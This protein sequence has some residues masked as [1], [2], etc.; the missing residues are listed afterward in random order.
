MDT[1][2]KIKIKQLQC[3]IDS[4]DKLIRAQQDMIETLK[5]LVQV[6]EL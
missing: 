3:V 2:D 5:A 4:Q 6:R 1:E